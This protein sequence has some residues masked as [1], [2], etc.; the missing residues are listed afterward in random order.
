MPFIDAPEL[1]GVLG[2]A[3]ATEHRALTGLLADRIVGRVSHGTASTVEPEILPDGQ[4]HRRGCRVPQLCDALGLRASW[5]ARR[6]GGAR[7][8]DDAQPRRYLGPCRASRTTWRHSLHAVCRGHSL[9]HS[10]GSRPAP[11][12][13]G[14]L[15]H[16]P[17]D[18]PS[19]P[20]TTRGPPHRHL[21]SAATPWT[22]GRLARSPRASRSRATLLPV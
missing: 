13:A 7:Q 15:E 1:A 20:E 22:Q 16:G 5:K 2:E 12:H 10:Q 3:P 11:D 6:L 21:G 19:G 17:H 8:P 4:W 14:H 9:R 18:R